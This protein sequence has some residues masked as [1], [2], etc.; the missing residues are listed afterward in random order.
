MCAAHGHRSQ[1]NG[2]R[3]RDTPEEIVLSPAARSRCRYLGIVTLG[4]WTIPSSIR[5]TPYEEGGHTIGV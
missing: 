2:D 5:H 4:E 1:S 3:G